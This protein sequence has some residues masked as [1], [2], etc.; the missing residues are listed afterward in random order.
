MYNIQVYICSGI[1]TGMY[2][3]LQVYMY[4]WRVQCTIFYQAGSPSADQVRAAAVAAV[5][6]LYVSSSNYLVLILFNV[7]QF[8]FFS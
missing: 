4:Y 8:I 6:N 7:E 2:N 1:R 3:N 5:H